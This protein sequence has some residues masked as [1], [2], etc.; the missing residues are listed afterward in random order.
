M[1]NEGVMDD[2][3]MGLAPQDNSAIITDTM[4][5][6]RRM[7]TFRRQY[8][9]RRAYWYRQY[10][11]QRDAGKYPD[12][13]TPRANIYV[14]YP[15]SNVE[16]VVSRTLD[17]FFSIDPYI[18][19]RGKG[20]TDEAAAPNMNVCL[21]SMLHRAKFQRQCEVLIRNIAIYGH[22]GW[23]VDWD[24]DFDIVTGPEPVYL[25]APETDPMTGQ[26]IL[27]AQ[28]HPNI[29]PVLISG[30]PIT[31]S[32]KVTTKLVP[33]MRPK[34]IPIDV[35]DLLL[36]P[37][38]GQIAHLFEKPLA[39][40]KREAQANPEMYLPGALD[41]LLKRVAGADEKDPDNVLVRFA[42]YWNEVDNTVRLIT[43]SEDNDAIAWKDLRY[44]YR[45]ANYSSYK[46][47]VFGGQPILFQYGPNPFLHKRA[48]I[49]HC[50]YTMLTGEPYGIGVVESISELT[51]AMNKFSN[52]I[53]DNWNMG[54]NRRYALDSNA[55]IDQNA[56]KQFNVPGGIV[57]VNG[58][59]EKVIFPLPVMTP[60][61]AEFTV[62][63]VVKNM[64]EL[65]SGISDFYGK[66]MGGPQGNRTSTGIGQVITE[67]N[68]LFKMFIRNFER[69][70]L[71]PTLEMCASNI[72]QYCTD[73]V[74]Y[75]VTQAPPG[76]PKVGRIP[77]EAIVGNYHFDFVGANYATN[78]VMRQRNMMAF[79][80]LASQTPYA[81]QGEFLRELGKVMEIP[82][83]A[84]LVKP[85]EQVMAEQQQG[86]AAQ[87]HAVLLDKVLDTESQILVAQ[88]AKKKEDDP[89]SVAH[90]RQVQDV[91]E[92]MLTAAGDLGPPP[93]A[94]PTPKAKE[95]RT[96]TR[97]P[98]GAIPGQGH[99]GATRSLAQ[100]MGSNAMGVGQMG[101]MGGT[102]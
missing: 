45:N 14:P 90:A 55:D 81:N 92:D 47:R 36:D 6:L 27:D 67:A 73:Y 40:L 33:R 44:S 31:I 9:P 58:E 98:E 84:R 57:T 12:N 64:I 101:E 89:E 102:E 7:R 87:Q 85:D 25:M 38:G 80:Q 79:Y 20:P 23:K 97:Q 21:L 16:A 56:L 68:Y 35:Y 29:M 39:Q 46:R 42:E 19:T 74:E 18:E 69:D 99:T 63:E 66:G 51:E 71:Q 43:F 93:G 4:S 34:I 22:A 65:S 41:E 95:G 61:P 83:A 15:R 3:S 52:M 62:L 11:S 5:Q 91:V 32:T 54:V 37:D 77:L 17:A 28:G 26:I 94:P 8:D 78:K 49:V 30:Q 88:A 82:N 86:L 10:L 75:Q 70:I 59:P 48:P 2:Q 72:Q 76:I 1:P 100:S 60:T 53:F 96:A 13:L 50:S 24:W